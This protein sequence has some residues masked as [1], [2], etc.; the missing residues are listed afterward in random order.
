[1][2][3]AELTAAITT[4]TS[5][6]FKLKNLAGKEAD[7]I[8]FMDRKLDLTLYDYIFLRKVVVA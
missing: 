6:L 4:P 2:I 7:I 8:K 5:K 3:A 1:L